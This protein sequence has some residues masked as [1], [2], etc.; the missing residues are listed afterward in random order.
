MRDSVAVDKCGHVKIVPDLVT[1][2]NQVALDSQGL[3]RRRYAQLLPG[4][5]VNLGDLKWPAAN[6]LADARFYVAELAK[7]DLAR[8]DP[9]GYP[10]LGGFHRLKDSIEARVEVRQHVVVVK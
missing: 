8:G 6:E 3:L 4:R 10:A 1:P 7:D 2:D 5:Q 9:V